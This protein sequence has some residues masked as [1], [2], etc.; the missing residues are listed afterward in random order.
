MTCGVTA[1]ARKES[2]VMSST[3]ST[4]F[5][6]ASGL[7]DG[8]ARPRCSSVEWAGLMVPLQL[9]SMPS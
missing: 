5:S 6:G 8:A 1:S 9:A 7:P 3:R 4:A 2:T